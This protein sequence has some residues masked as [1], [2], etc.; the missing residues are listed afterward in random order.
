MLLLS[1]LFIGLIYW[2]ICQLLC[3]LLCRPLGQLFCPALSASLSASLL[4]LS[5]LVG[6]IGLPGLADR[7]V[8]ERIGHAIMPAAHVTP[9]DGGETRPRADSHPRQGMT[10]WR[11]EERRVGKECRSRWS[12]Y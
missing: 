11:S 2:P 10:A 4:A 1:P 7:G 8:R 3:Q 5:G 12:P 9:P 6:F